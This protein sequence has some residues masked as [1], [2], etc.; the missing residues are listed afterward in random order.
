MVVPGA[1]RAASPVN[2]WPWPFLRIAHRGLPGQAP[3]NSLQGF[4]MAAALG[5]DM[6][7]TD[8]RLSADGVAVLAHDD[9]VEGTGAP[10]LYVSRTALVD[11]RRRVPGAGALPTLDEALALRQ[12]GAPL[13][14]NLDIKQEGVAPPLLQAVRAT[15][16][17][18]GLLLTGHTPQ[19]F[20]AVR[21]QEPW[22]GAALTRAAR[23]PNAPARALARVLPRP[24]GMLLGLYLVAQ[25]R[26]AG[27]HALTLE[28]TLATPEVVQICHRAGLH[29]LVWTVDEPC[30]MRALHAGGVDGITTNR[31]GTLIQL[32]G[33]VS[34]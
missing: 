23:L 7:E 21:V 26:A 27:V 9:E 28:Y 25:A 31:V 19:V 33:R 16:R 13:A 4:M 5:A 17:R 12:H 29:V 15:G 8:V 34:L 2:A 1:D 14:F 24:G 18:D 22:I 30:T 6:V 3:E 11:L 32:T 10:H 20:A